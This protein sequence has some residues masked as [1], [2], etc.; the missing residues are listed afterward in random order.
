LGFHFGDVILIIVIRIIPHGIG[1]RRQESLN[2]AM[3]G[4]G[5]SGDLADEVCRHYH[6]Q[7][8][9]VGSRWHLRNW[10]YTLIWFIW[11]VK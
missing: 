5:L 4:Q 10:F 9:E 7:I 8:K 11:Q 1:V 2:E 3:M 6:R